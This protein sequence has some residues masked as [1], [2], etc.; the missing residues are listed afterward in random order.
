M[1][2]NSILLD[3][4]GTLIVQMMSVHIGW[5]TKSPRMGCY[6]PQYTVHATPKQNRQFIIMYECYPHVA[7]A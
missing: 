1:I 5:S 2:S 3:V 4:T 6:D 7:G